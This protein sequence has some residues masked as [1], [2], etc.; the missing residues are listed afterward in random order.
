MCGGRGC[1]LDADREKPLVA[2][3]GVAMVDRVRDALAAELDTVY[4]VTAPATPATR[5][6]LDPPV[7]DAPGEGYVADLAYALDR[8][9]RPVVTATADLPFLAP[10]HVRNLLVAHE[11]H[12]L[13][14]AVP[15][16]LRRALGLSIDRTRTVDGQCVVPT[17]LGLVDSGVPEW[18]VWSDADLAVEVDRPGDRVLAEGYA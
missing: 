8:V 5:D 1:R 14:V 17:G 10:D 16:A 6:R 7:I 3:D 9:D 13:A 18:L 11:G 4:A 12:D 2:I 15:I